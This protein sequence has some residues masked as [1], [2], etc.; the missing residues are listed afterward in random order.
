MQ[1]N[2]KHEFEHFKGQEARRT[3]NQDRLN[4]MFKNEGDEY[5]IGY[6]TT[7]I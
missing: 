5:G 2:S 7:P 6:I 1:L 3:T 4:N